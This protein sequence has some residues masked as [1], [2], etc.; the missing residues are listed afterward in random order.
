MFF[1]GAELL[2]TEALV[3]QLRTVLVGV[4]IGV[5]VAMP[6]GVAGG[7]AVAAGAG[8]SS[9]ARCMRNARLGRLEGSASTR[10][11]KS[12]APPIATAKASNATDF[13]PARARPQH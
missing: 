7:V 13:M 4:A 9:L 11:A 2:T 5:A 10:P 8:G 1:W 3:V 12:A 6:V